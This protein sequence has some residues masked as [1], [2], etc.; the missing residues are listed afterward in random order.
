MWIPGLKKSC[1][2]GKCVQDMEFYIFISF[3][4]DSVA[5]KWETFK[6]VLQNQILCPKE[7]DVFTCSRF[8]RSW[9]RIIKIMLKSWNFMSIFLCEPCHTTERA[10]DLLCFCR[11]ADKSVAMEK[12]EAAKPAL[13]EAEAALGTI[14]PAHISTVRKLAKPPHLIMR[15]MDCVLL[16]FQKKVDAVTADPER[17]CC[18]P[19]WSESLKMMAQG[20][21]LQSLLTFPKVGSHIWSRRSLSLQGHGT[22]A[23]QRKWHQIY[24][25]SISIHLTPAHHWTWVMYLLE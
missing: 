18:K 11:Q 7:F 16:L 8:S 9:N 25:R 15:I 6:N 2:F 13:E 5:N 12:L 4:F 1:N 19:S 10:F 14:K 24:F 20:G 17:P 23:D 22:N 3:S 21:F